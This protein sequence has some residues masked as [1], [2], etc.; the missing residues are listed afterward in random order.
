MTRSN[1]H[2]YLMVFLI[3][4]CIFVATV[5]SG[6]GIASTA[7]AESDDVQT[8]YEKTNVLDNLKGSVIGGKEF[9]INDF[10]HDSTGRPQ[11]ISFVEFCYSYYADKQSDYGLYVYVYNPQDTAIDINTE[12]NK[13]QLTYGDKAGYSKYVLKF[14]NYSNEPGYEGRFYKFKIKLSLAERNSILNTVKPD[15]RIY[16]V[17]GIELS[18]KNKVTE[19]TCAQMYT[20]TGFALGYGSEL[21]DSDTLSCIV[22]GFDKYLTLD[23]RSTFWRPDGTHADLHSRDTLHSVYFAVPNEIVEEYGEMTGV[24]ATWLNAQTAP[25]IVTGNK[26]VY[27]AIE[28]YIAK[29][30]DAGSSEKYPENKTLNYALVTD[31]DMTH[32]GH[33]HYG[34]LAYNVWTTTDTGSTKK[35]YERIIYELRYLFY[36]ENGNADKY[37]LPSERLLGD[38]KNGI[39]GWLETYTEKFGGEKINNRYSKDLFDQVDDEFT[40]VNITANDSFR[41][42]D[43]NTTDNWW[44]W[45]FGAGSD[46]IVSGTNTYDISAIQKVTL[47]DFNAYSDKSIFSDKFFIDKADYEEL[48]EYVTEAAANKETVYLFRYYQSIYDSQEAREFK[49]VEDW[50]MSRGTFGNYEELDTNAYIAQMWI[51]LDFDI[52]DLTFTKDGVVTIIPVIMS[53]MDI[54]A[55]AAPPVYTTGDNEGLTWWQILLAILLGILVFILLL[56]FAPGIVTI[57]IKI[58]L[59]PFKLIAALFKGLGTAI[60]PI[61]EKN[62]VKRAERREQR[63]MAREERKEQKRAEREQKKIEKRENKEAERERKFNE[64]QDRKLQNSERMRKE[65]ARKKRDKDFIKWMNKEQRKSDKK[66]C[67]LVKKEQKLRKQGV[68]EDEINEILTAMDEDDVPSFYYFLHGEDL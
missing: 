9:D 21:A 41:L 18:V 16:K 11:I 51:Q 55:D 3:V 37:T 47:A 54:A 14:I 8:R 12:R 53:P 26:K 45:L 19:Y 13:I 5:F 59:L 29:H 57:L 62:K 2:D 32:Y 4:V 10:S 49:F 20:Y 25:I 24:H 60:K 68:S 58:I 28:P 22:D 23:V 38:E 7:Y 65:K 33:G 36:A 56:K 61:Y 27:N 46:K 63:R 1:I 64:K 43:V 67:Q 35:C 39:K 6:W 34:T 15:R 44:G 50:A 42:T 30:Q 31:S 17:S 52:I 66:A 40:E 48:R